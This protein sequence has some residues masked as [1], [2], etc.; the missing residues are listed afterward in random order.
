MSP[1][2]GG[3]GLER[4][5]AEAQLSQPPR[6][7]ETTTRFDARHAWTTATYKGLVVRKI[8]TRADRSFTLELRYR[9]DVVLIAIDKDGV[10]SVGRL[11]QSV[12]VDSPEALEQVQQVLGGSQAIFAFRALLAERESVSDLKGP[13]FTLLAAAAFTASLVGDTDAP[14]RLTARFVQLH[15]GIVRSVRAG[16]EKCWEQYTNETV[17]AWDELQDCMD[18]ANQDS[19]VFRAAYRRLACNAVWALRSDAAFFELIQCLNPLAIIQ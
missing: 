5:T 15:R 6:G 14:R 2:A 12:L 7:P 13:E 10:P 4:V 11:D 18:E 8:T 19:N 17:G 1:A 16:G 3:D 9:Q